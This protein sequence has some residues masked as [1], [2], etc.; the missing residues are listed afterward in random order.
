MT[1]I[2]S[3]VCKLEPWFVGVVE[4]VDFEHSVVTTNDDIR[5]A[6]TREVKG[7]EARDPAVF[8]LV[9]H[10]PAIAGLRGSQL[11]QTNL[12]ILSAI[13]NLLS[14]G[15]LMEKRGIKH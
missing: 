1:R 11:H 3:Y 6:V 4:T 13:E 7:R 5:Q 15:P 8:S 14:V 9:E 10:V 2:L 12:T